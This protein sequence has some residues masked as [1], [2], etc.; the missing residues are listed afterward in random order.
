MTLEIEQ[1]DVLGLWSSTMANGSRTLVLT[2]YPLLLQLSCR[3]LG[4]LY[5]DQ[6][7][8]NRELTTGLSECQESQRETRDKFSTGMNPG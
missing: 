2:L 3:E 7:K 5:I 4:I 8:H 1:L 6:K